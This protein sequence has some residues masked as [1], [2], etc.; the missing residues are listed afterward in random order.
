MAA[1]RT[2]PLIAL[3]GGGSGG[4]LYPMLSV[5]RELR[6]RSPGARFMFF[7]TRRP[8]DVRLIRSAMVD[9]AGFEVIEQNVQPLPRS[10]LDVVGF[11]RAWRA[12]TR[13]CT[14]RFRDDRPVVV[15]G[16]GGYG[17]GPAIR[18]ASSLGIRT[19]LLNPDAMPGRAN[20]YLARWADVVFAQ[21]PITALHLSRSANVRVVG[22]PIRDTFA[23][24]RRSDGGR[25]FG[26]D[27]AGRTLLV[28]GASQ[29]A[30]TINQ[31]MIAIAD[32]LA[33][34]RWQVLHLAGEDEV[35]S[36]RAAYAQ[37]GV[38]AIV[39]A[40]TDHMPE[41]LAAADL[42]LSRAGAST[43]AE[44]TAV[45]VASVLM[46]YPH[47]RH[48]HQAANA[49]VLADARAAEV[50]EDRIDPHRNGPALRAVLGR[51]MSDEGVLSRMA[52]KARGLGTHDAAS[53]IAEALLVSRVTERVES[54]RI[55]ARSPY[56]SVAVDGIDHPRD[57]PNCESEA[58]GRR[59]PK[60]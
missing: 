36:V 11:L 23:A 27:P 30:R 28:T 9:N 39:L 44:M 33:V 32:A 25:R 13:L 6:R 53:T 41:A 31:A 14:C 35:A 60:L 4:H 58:I 54:E 50:V 20:S 34:E 43:L 5:V 56:R 15:I 59:A 1:R 26:L 55:S 18:A 22:C 38:R 7:T 21:W 12:S 2:G 46:P 19:A 42:V 48:R 3:A 51:L 57:P 37:H 52:A 16:S 24:A 40:Y 45:G 49:K 29:G 8:I 47:D 17:S 10:I